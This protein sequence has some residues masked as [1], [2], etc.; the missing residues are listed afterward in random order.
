[1][2]YAK[3]DRHLIK[4]IAA[5]KKSTHRHQ[6]EY[7]SQLFQTRLLLQSSLISTYSHNYLLRLVE[8]LATAD[9]V[10]GVVLF[11]SMGWAV[12]PSRM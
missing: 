5:Y 1:M 7:L 6:P 11:N 10:I 12:P 3:S 8:I 2:N 4:H 9:D